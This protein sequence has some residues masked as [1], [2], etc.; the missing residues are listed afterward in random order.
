M[1]T[2]ESSSKQLAVWTMWLQ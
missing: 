2:L 1:T